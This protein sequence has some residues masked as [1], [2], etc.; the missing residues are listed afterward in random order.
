MNSQRLT[1]HRDIRTW[2]EARHGRPALRHVLTKSGGVEA[3]LAIRFRR[4]EAPLFVPG[5]DDGMS[6]CS[7]TAWMAELDRQ[8]LALEVSDRSGTRVEF[9]DRTARH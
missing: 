2:V 4:Q 7:W 5:Q 3:R 9:V 1:D 6:P 8:H